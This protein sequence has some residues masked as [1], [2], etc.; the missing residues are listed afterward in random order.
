[1]A[2]TRSAQKRIRSDERKRLRNQKVRSRVKTFVKKA[3]QNIVSQDEVTVE[4]IRLACSE[5]DKAVS[6]GVLHKNNAARRK[7]RLMAKFNK[8]NAAN[9][10][11]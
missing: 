5:L 11:A 9:A 3:E 6:K 2:N 1:M 7:S 10:A 4:S 8:A